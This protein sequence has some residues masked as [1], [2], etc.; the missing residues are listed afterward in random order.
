MTAKIRYIL[1]LAVAS[2]VFF[3]CSKDQL[4]GESLICEETIVYED[5]RDVISASCGYTPCHNGID[6]GE[7]YNNFAGLES[8]LKSGSF[9]SSVLIVRDMPP[10]D[11]QGNPNA[12][13]PDDNPTS[14]TDEEI[15]LIQCWEQN[16]FSEF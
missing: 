9:S 6:R 5:V 3:A 14:L 1:L 15:K 4:D 8:Y 13:P 7:N 2:L 16:G 12:N 10:G 11:A